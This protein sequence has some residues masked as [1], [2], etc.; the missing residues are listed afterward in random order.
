MAS[1]VGMVNAALQQ[2]K[3]TKR[4]ASFEDGT[5]EANAA[6]EVF[7]ELRDLLLDMHLWNFATLRVKLAR[8]EDTPAFGWLYQYAL[9][10]DFIRLSAIYDNT[11]ERGGLSY[12]IENGKILTDASDV[13]LKYI[14]R[15]SDPNQMPPTFRNALTTLLA[16]RLAT[17]V[18]QSSTLAK[19]MRSVFN[20]EDLPTAKSIDA[21]QDH[22]DQL[23]ESSW[24]STRYGRRDEYT[25]GDPPAS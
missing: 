17:A 21:L 12:R 23:P 25:P 4:I 5:K 22:A 10:S 1:D 18:A 13:Y 9:P 20:D 2:L 8:E 3:S 24:I 6:A 11:N 16:A 14:A 7:D 19:E 15:V